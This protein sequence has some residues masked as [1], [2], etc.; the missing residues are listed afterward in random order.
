MKGEIEK[1]LSTYPKEDALESTV[2]NSRWVRITYG[3]N[4]FYVFG[5]IYSGEKPHYICYGVPA[6]DSYRPPESLQ[7][8]AS[9]IP[10]SPTEREKGYW[11]MYQDA[12]TGASVKISYK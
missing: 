10:S 12:D 2:E 4:K 7:G 3:G 1:V 5:V 11:V 8:L 9:F 6:T